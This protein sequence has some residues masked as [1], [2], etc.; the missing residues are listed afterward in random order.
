MVFFLKKGNNPNKKTTDFF[1]SSPGKICFP[2]CGHHNFATAVMQ[3]ATISLS[4]IWR[5]DEKQEAETEPN[6]KRDLKWGV[7]DAKASFLIL[8]SRNKGFFQIIFMKNRKPTSTCWEQIAW[9]GTWSLSSVNLVIISGERFH[10]SD[11]LKK[12]LTI[13]LALWRRKIKDL[14]FRK[15]VQDDRSLLQG[16]EFPKLSRIHVITVY[17]NRLKVCFSSWLGL[18]CKQT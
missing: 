2:H 11:N 18:E 7:W 8:F 17:N 6:F 10:L 4:W 13:P 3:S 14:S 1:S 12:S 9:S 16:L 5:C 15:N